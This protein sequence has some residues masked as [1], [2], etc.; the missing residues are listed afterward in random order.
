MVEIAVKKEW[1]GKNLRQLD[2]RR[3]YGVN[4]IAYDAVDEELIVNIPPD[5]PLKEGTIW[6]TGTTKAV[7]QVVNK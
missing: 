1:V 3:E 2:F 5:M 7:S 6:V 4:V